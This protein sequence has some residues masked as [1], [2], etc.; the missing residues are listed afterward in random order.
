MLAPRS[1]RKPDTVLMMPG[2]SG[3]EASRRNVSRA[4][5]D[6]QFRVTGYGAGGEILDDHL[7]QHV[8][9]RPGPVLEVEV[10][11]RRP[12]AA[13]RLPRLRRPRCQAGRLDVRVVDA[14]DQRDADRQR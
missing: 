7:A 11:A 9:Y 4:M 8:G 5:S 2:R 12:V 1:Y 14:V 13:Y 6:Q 3:Q 10:A